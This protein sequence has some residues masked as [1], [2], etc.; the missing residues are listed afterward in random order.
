MWKAQ[1]SLLLLSAATAALL[2]VDAVRSE[3][4][5]V[6]ALDAY[7]LVGEHNLHSGFE[8][9]SGK[10]RV[11]VVVEMPAGSSEKW[12]VDPQDG[13]L[14][15]QIKNGLPR[16]VDYLPLPVNYG[17][18]PGTWSIAWGAEEEPLD[19][20]VLGPAAERGTL[21]HA[22]VLGVLRIAQDGVRDDKLITVP[23]EGPFSEVADL[24]ELQ[25]RYPGMLELLESWFAGASRGEARGIGDLA[26]ARGLVRD[27]VRSFRSRD[28]LDQDRILL[29]SR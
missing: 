29:S 23:E 14:R 7:T 17:S 27:S 19:A 12:E 9:L 25:A 4:V 28:G 6:R 24:A 13:A 18:I 5:G 22:R 1:H 26:E 3:T 2:G 16:H 21:L 11:R 15:L 20:M 10:D 8:A